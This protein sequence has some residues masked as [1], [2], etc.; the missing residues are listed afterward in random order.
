MFFLSMHVRFLIFF[1][2]LCTPPSNKRF[3]LHFCTTTKTTIF[4]EGT[5]TWN[6]VVASKEFWSCHTKNGI[7]PYVGLLCA[8][9]DRDSALCFLVC[10]RGCSSCS[11]SQIPFTFC[12]NLCPFEGIAV[13]TSTCTELLAK[14]N[15]LHT[16]KTVQVMKIIG[17]I[18]LFA[19]WVYAERDSAFTE[20]KWI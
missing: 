9:R 8:L 1:F 2:L 14:D 10:C 16:H 6:T 11:G 13:I 18:T 19:F 15:T 3:S 7:R 20:R 4:S 12:P 17:F 5:Q